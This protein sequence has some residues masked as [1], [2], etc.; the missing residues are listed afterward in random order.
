MLRGLP[1]DGLA[2]D[3]FIAA[4]W[5]VGTW[6]GTPLSQNAQGELIGHVL[7]AT[8]EDATPRMYRSNLEL[9]LHTDWTAMIT[10]ACWQQAASRGGASFLTSAH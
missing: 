7:D 8:A 9:R 3:D 10:L 6:F 1:V 2:V 4:V 5:G